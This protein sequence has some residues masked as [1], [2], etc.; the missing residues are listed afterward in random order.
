MKERK[1]K[2]LTP[3]KLKEI[4]YNIYPENIAADLFKKLAGK[5]RKKEQKNER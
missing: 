3:E 4:L 5:S 2:E 1:G